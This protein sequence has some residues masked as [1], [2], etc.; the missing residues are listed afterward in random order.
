MILQVW[1]A[2]HLCGAV[3]RVPGISGRTRYA[4]R[5]LQLPV[6]RSAYRDCR[7]EHATHTGIPRANVLFVAAKRT[8]NRLSPKSAP[9]PPPVFWSVS[10]FALCPWLWGC[11]KCLRCFC[12]F[13]IP[14]LREA[15]GLCISGLALCCL[16]RAKK[17][18]CPPGAIPLRHFPRL[19]GRTL[20]RRHGL[21]HHME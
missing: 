20:R 2:H 19:A 5:L 4:Y 12:P 10:A 3:Q 21:M 9:F 16:G 14:G 18:A 6:V 8:K 17:A 11:S 7:S 13:S 15:F 1:M